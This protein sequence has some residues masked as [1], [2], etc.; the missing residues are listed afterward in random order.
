M[1]AQ[2]H[3]HQHTHRKSF[4][5]VGVQL[6]RRLTFFIVS[7]HAVFTMLFLARVWG[8]FWHVKKEVDIVK[9]AFACLS[10]MVQIVGILCNMYMCAFTH[11]QPRTKLCTIHPRTLATTLTQKKTTNHANSEHIRISLTTIGVVFCVPVGCALWIHL[12]VAVA[13]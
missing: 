2:T 5:Y 7:N 13:S 9:N 10:D 8:V 6:V 12:P 4:C 1:S 3:R 11:E